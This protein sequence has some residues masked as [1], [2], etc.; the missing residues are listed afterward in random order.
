MFPSTAIN[1]CCGHNTSRKTNNMFNMLYW[2]HCVVY[3]AASDGKLNYYS[4]I[5]SIKQLTKPID[6]LSCYR[7]QTEFLLIGIDAMWWFVFLFCISR[8]WI[9]HFAKYFLTGGWK[10][11]RNPYLLLFQ[12]QIRYFSGISM[13]LELIKFFF[14]WYLH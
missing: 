8:V 10:Q 6:T 14:H 12:R 13:I 5:H 3:V 9:Q 1:V 11:S 7:V 2:A 4:S